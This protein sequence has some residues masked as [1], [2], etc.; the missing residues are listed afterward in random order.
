MKCP[1]SPDHLD[2]VAPAFVETGERPLDPGRKIFQHDLCGRMD[3]QGGCREIEPWGLGRQEQ[4]REGVCYG[5]P[6]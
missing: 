2:L 3:A 1:L 6:F 5:T 4:A